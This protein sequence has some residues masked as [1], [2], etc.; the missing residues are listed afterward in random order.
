ML[1]SSELSGSMSFSFAFSV[2][3]LNILTSSCRRSLTT[4][5]IDLR[6]L[7]LL[8]AMVKAGNECVFKEKM[9]HEGRGTHGE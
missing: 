4:V 7:P 2:L 8:S 5:L 3:S 1:S 9:K 6:L